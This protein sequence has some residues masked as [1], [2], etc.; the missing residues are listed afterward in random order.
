MGERTFESEEDEEGE[1]VHFLSG[2]VDMAEEAKVVIVLC[3][4]SVDPLTPDQ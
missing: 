4:L 3:D 1:I 2:R